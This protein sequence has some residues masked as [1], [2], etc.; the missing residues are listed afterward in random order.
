MLRFSGID[1]R[2]ERAAWLG[3]GVFV[4]LLV[5]GTLAFTTDGMLRAGA[6]AVKWALNVAHHRWPRSAELPDRVLQ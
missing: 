2:V 5:V 3:S 6:R 1:A 4:L